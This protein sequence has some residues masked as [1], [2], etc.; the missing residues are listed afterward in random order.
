[1]DVLDA[2]REQEGEVVPGQTCDE[3]G[4]PEG[5]GLPR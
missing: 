3:E 4:K 1:M 5:N 2:L